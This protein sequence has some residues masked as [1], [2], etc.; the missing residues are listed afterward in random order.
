MEQQPVFA[1]IGAGAMGEAILGGLIRQ[2]LTKTESIYASEPR[3]SRRVELKD[4]YGIRTTKNNLEAI[5]DADV[6]VLA[7]KPQRLNKI[8]EELKD[9]IPKKAVIISIIAGA[10]VKTISEG[11]NHDAVVRTMPN[12]PGQI[13][14]G[15]TVWYPNSSVTEQHLDFSQINVKSI[16]RRCSGRRGILSGYGYCHIRNRSNVCISFHGSINGCGCPPWFFQAYR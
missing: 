3:E 8:L 10:S 1:I 12:T 7:V 15:I 11:L 5:Q 9:K 4:R 16:G 6:V 14:K 2:N 13:G